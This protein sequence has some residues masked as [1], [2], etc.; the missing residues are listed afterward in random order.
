MGNN[1]GNTPLANLR[2]T[3]CGGAIAS[4]DTFLI[5]TEAGGGSYIFRWWCY[6]LAGVVA[7]V[8]EAKLVIGS[9]RC[10]RHY[11]RNLC[12]AEKGKHLHG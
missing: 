10:A 12:L 1:N 8:Q 4:S 6:H 5:V 3:L 9:A 2:C 7:A 11:F